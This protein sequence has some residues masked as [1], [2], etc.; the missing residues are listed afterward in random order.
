MGKPGEVHWEEWMSDNKRPVE[1]RGKPTPGEAAKVSKGESGNATATGKE[2]VGDQPR[3][4]TAGGQVV[5]E[6][7]KEM[8]KSMAAVDLGLG[9][10]VLVKA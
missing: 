2:L 7:V 10:V 6:K 8:E 1:E 3:L 9:A 4:K 5:D